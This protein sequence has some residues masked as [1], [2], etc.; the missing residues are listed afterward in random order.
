MIN[1]Y[2]SKNN[3]YNLLGNKKKKKNLME[4]GKKC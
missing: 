4:K 2:N 1:L 3:Y